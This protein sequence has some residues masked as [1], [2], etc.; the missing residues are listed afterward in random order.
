MDW[1]HD[2]MATVQTDNS[3][4]ASFCNLYVE[5]LTSNLR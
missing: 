1:E 4:E 2:E 5:T 3:S